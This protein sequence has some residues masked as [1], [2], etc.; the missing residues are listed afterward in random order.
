MSGDIG[1]FSPSIFAIPASSRVAHLMK[2]PKPQ[3]EMSKQ[4]NKFALHRFY[5]CSDFALP[6][7]RRFVYLIIGCSVS[8]M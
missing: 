8:H 1:A 7:A 3:A 4:A 2:N 6:D 5:N